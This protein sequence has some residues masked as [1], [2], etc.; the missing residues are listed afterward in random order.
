[1]VIRSSFFLSW[2]C[3]YFLSMFMRLCDETDYWSV[4]KL[5]CLYEEACCWCGSYNLIPLRSVEQVVLYHHNQMIVQ[6]ME[7]VS[8]DTGG[9]SSWEKHCCNEKWLWNNDL[10]VL[11]FT[12]ALLL[13]DC[14]YATFCKLRALSAHLSDLYHS[15]VTSFFITE[16][17][18][19]IITDILTLKELNCF[20]QLSFL[21][22]VKIGISNKSPSYFPD[23]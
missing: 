8:G 1:M 23:L 12:P 10:F 5:I 4:L 20:Q 22:S 16:Q 6:G 17:K 14:T 18:T 15:V 9:R 19:T 21:G 7:T 3:P 11:S 2:F 13:C